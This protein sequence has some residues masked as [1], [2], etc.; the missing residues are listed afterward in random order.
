ML[1]DKLNNIKLIRSSDI[2]N[3]LQELILQTFD[4]PQ[5][6]YVWLSNWIASIKDRIYDGW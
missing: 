6:R 5:Y 3:E 2:N 4:N 1:I